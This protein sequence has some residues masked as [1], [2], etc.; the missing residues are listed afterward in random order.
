MLLERED[1]LRL[2]GALLDRARRGNGGIALVEGAAGA[3]KT[4]LLAHI[5]DRTSGLQGPVRDRR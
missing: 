2:L 1:E 3:G 4:A 5:R